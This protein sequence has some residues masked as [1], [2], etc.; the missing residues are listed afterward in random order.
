MRSQLLTWV[1]RGASFAIG[2]GLVAI[3]AFIAISALDVVFLV[4]LAILLGA[5]LEPVV[6]WLRSRLPIGRAISILI[7]Y[8]LFL[9]LVVV[10]GVVIV[11][12]AAT[13]IELAVARL[14]TFLESI[15]SATAGLRPD[16]LA[17]GVSGLIDAAEQVLHPPAP[18]AGTVV[19]ASVA[20]AS[21]VAAVVT[22]LTLVFFWLTERSRLQRYALAFVPRHRRAGIRDGWN[23]VETRLGL[24]VRGQLI[25]MGTLGVLTGIA[26]SLL[27]LPAALLLA[28]IAAL[29][30]IVPIAGPLIG[31][32][33][34][35]LVATTVS[36]ETALLTLGV[37]VAIQFIEGNVLVPIV[38]RNAIGLSPFLV[39]VSILTGFT[40]GGPLG[41]IVA[42][43]LVAAVEA[44]LERL[45]ARRIPVPLDPAAVEPPSPDEREALEERAPGA[46]TPRRRRRTKSDRARAT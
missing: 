13:Q 20:V 45:Q 39:A 3:V 16:V 4:F 11:P 9:T 46:P 33:P 1:V 25:L 27:G 23:E 19:G 38:M 15:R 34:A 40:A 24:W 8:V 6:A 41:A 2:V 31:A 14:P 5:G 26:Y 10:L 21:V 28:L 12:A 22:L 36:T 18:D 37:Y 43:P 7:V 30:E 44:V 35:L 17:Q 32:I 29:A 42:V